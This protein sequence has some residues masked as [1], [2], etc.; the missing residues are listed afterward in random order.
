MTTQQVAAKLG[1]DRAEI[2]IIVNRYPHLRPAK[3]WGQ[4]YRW[5]EAEIAALQAYLVS[6]KHGQVDKST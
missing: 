2:L 6:S 3:R 4:S 1:I 5:E